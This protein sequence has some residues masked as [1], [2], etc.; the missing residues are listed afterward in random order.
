MKISHFLTAILSLISLFFL[1][2]SFSF[3]LPNHNYVSISHRSF[4]NRKMLATNFDFSPFLNRHRHRHTGTRIDPRY[5]AE[6]RIVP[7]GPNPLHH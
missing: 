7:T 2:F 4:I 6:K 3:F 5:G 1:I